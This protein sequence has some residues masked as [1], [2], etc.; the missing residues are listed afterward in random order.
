M[1]QSMDK[2]RIKHKATRSKDA[3]STVGFILMLIYVI[4]LFI[5]IV[6]ALLTS[7]KSSE[8][9]Y[10]NKF[11]LPS[12]WMFSNYAVAFRRMNVTINTGKRIVPVYT[13]QMFIFSLMWTAGATFATQFVHAITAYGCARYKSFTGKMIHRIVL[14]CMVLPIIGSLPSEMQVVRSLG[15]YNNMIGM[16]I[17]K[18][19]F[20]GTDF[21]IYYAAFKSLSQEYS[22]AAQI[23]G[24]GPFTI[25]FKVMFPM[26]LPMIATM[27]LLSII[28]FWNDY[29]TSLTYMPNIPT[30]AFGLFRYQFSTDQLVSSIPMQLTGCM[31]VVLP[32]VCIFLIFRNKLV[33]NVS[34]G[35]LK[36]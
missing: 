11:G 27:S 8:D 2:K 33:M 18:G 1:L 30:L 7:L 23:D 5:P 29:G 20:L 24:A 35:G 19:N 26:I 34:L 6:W 17:M 15:F 28:G 32:I 21:L 9:F 16:F 4:S 13:W 36:G 22:N 25:M 12:E 31:I 3:L 10:Y 14:F